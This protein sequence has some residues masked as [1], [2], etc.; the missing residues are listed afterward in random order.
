M[1]RYEHAILMQED[2]LCMYL[3]Q[4]GI[5]LRLCLVGVVSAAKHDSVK[6][7]QACTKDAVS[8]AAEVMKT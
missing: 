7:V 2:L 6:R 3:A 1:N 8:G 5:V 4:A